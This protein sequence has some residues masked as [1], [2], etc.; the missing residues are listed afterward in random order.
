MA[1]D[2]CDGDDDDGKTIRG[3][4][5]GRPQGETRAYGTVRLLPM[6]YNSWGRERWMSIGVKRA[7][8]VC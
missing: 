4:H 1:T 5:K 8:H 7:R 2:N 6:E 3:D